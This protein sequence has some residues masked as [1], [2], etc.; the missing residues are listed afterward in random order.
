MKERERKLV[1]LKRFV[2]RYGDVIVNEDIDENKVKL[3]AYQTVSYIAR[4][5]PGLP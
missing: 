4:P 1:D 5:S 3:Q 2:K